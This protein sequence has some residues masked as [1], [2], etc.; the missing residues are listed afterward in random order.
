M[1]P[2]FCGRL[3][4]LHE[5]KATLRR[6]GAYFQ[7]CSTAFDEQTATTMSDSFDLG[8]PFRVLIL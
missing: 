2:P 3:R 8:P 6:L 7:P 5:Q 4:H 1:S